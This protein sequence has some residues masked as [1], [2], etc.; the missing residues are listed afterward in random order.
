MSTDDAMEV[1]KAIKQL[2]LTL[3]FILGALIYI[4]LNIK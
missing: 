1:V 2:D 4:G 3:M